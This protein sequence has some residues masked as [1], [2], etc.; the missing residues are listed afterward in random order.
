MAV[1]DES[2][3][4]RL[5]PIADPNQTA[6]HV[7]INY[8]A[9][10]LNTKASVTQKHVALIGSADDGEPGVIYK[11][12]NLLDA[13]RIFH[14]G[15][16]V[17]AASLV[18]SPNKKVMQGGG[19]IY[20]M[21]VEN[22]TQA[23]LNAS[24]LRFKSKIWGAQ[25]NKI[26]IA[27]ERDDLTNAYEVTIDY[28]PD[29]Y[30]RRYTG[31]GQ[32]FKLQYQGN[33][34]DAK[35]T[36]SV[37][38][39]PQTGL[40]KTFVL[41]ITD[42]DKP[43]ATTTLAPT[44]TNSTFKPLKPTTTL[45]DSD[46]ADYRGELTRAGEAGGGDT[47]ATDTT[48][49]TENPADAS[50]TSTS[51]T[52]PTTST[53]TPTKDPATSTST[54]DPTTTST[55]TSTSTTDP[56]TTS[57][58]STSTTVNED[59]N[60]K[61]A[62]HTLHLEYDLN[63]DQYAK[64]YDL[65][66]ALDLIPNLR[67]DLTLEGDNVRM[68][69]NHLDEAKAV[70]ITGDINSLDK[71]AYV[72]SV[73]SDIVDKL[74]L[75]DCVSVSAV[76]TEPLNE[77]FGLT[78]MEKGSTAGVPLSWAEQ[79]KKFAQCPA[80]YIVPLTASAPIHQEVKEFVLEQSALTN[81]IRAFVGCG[82]NEGKGNAISRQLDLSTS[83]V[84]LVVSSGYFQ[85]YDDVTVHLP[86]YMVACLAAGVQSG[87]PIGGD[88]TN[89]PINM[90][91]L[92]QTFNQ[93]EID[94]LYNNGIITVKALLNRG[95][96]TGYAFVAGITTYVPKTNIQDEPVK[97]KIGLGE[98]TDFMFGDMRVKLENA[99]IGNK[100]YKTTASVVKNF[101]ASLLSSYTM[102]PDS[103]LVDYDED[104]ISV[105][106]N[107]ATMTISFSVRPSQ[108]IDYIHVY[109]TFDNYIDS[110]SGTSATPGALNSPSQRILY[111]DYG[112]MPSGAGNRF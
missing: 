12:D 48:S 98:I 4:E 90:L 69:S 8:N 30:H 89:K 5:Y 60:Q 81:P 15:D 17:E 97:R 101:V 14:G 87:L 20:A 45:K 25:A 57:T 82:F 61:S 27:M 41:D 33:S 49:T 43:D 9:D 37:I 103:E 52:D 92:D 16:I 55:S 77:P 100:V 80:Y 21:R 102:D 58:T 74:A 78:P 40:A 66:K 38:T 6:P 71:C 24:G 3:F 107:G 72:W 42:T 84:G 19:T 54:T 108:T 110:S 70:D 85:T 32:L 13:K 26:K 53:S 86:G 31:L 46:P 94:I 50:T 68:Y 23:V 2:N 56:T 105:L 88:I 93:N 39:D 111:G 28:V 35:A 112:D 95:E 18:W 73:R 44:T 29:H 91:S 67:V 75:D 83:R 1:I 62:F 59:D 65:M 99:F 76:Y 109:G 34:K 10:A 51:T 36:Y 104:S 79:I 22:A 64:V 11:I 96:T 106:V 7:D 47:S 63:T